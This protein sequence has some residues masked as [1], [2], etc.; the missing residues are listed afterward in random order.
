MTSVLFALVLGSALGWFVARRSSSPRGLG[1]AAGAHLLPDPA[2]QWL[3]R[4][5]RGLGV[6]VAEYD[7]EEQAPTLERVLDAD[8][9]PPAQVAA[10]DRR[11]ERAREQE[12]GGAERLDAGLFVMRASGGCAV[13]LL[14]A[15]AEAL[16]EVEADLD[17]LLA[18]VR[19][20]PIVSMAQARPDALAIESVGSVSLRLAYQLERITNAAVVVASKDIDGVRVTGTSGHADRRLLD[21]LLPSGSG[22]ARAAGGTLAEDGVQAD[23][24]G[25]TGDRRQGGGPAFVVRIRSGS[26]VVGAVAVWVPGGGEP[27]G[28]ALG[29]ILECVREAGPR[30]DNAQQH[31]NKAKEAATDRLTG[32]ANRRALEAA[33]SRQGLVRGVLVVLDIDHFKRLNDAL[34][35]PAGDAALLHVGQLIREQ[36]RTSDTA[37]RIGGEEFALWLPGADLEIGRRTADRIRTKLGTT[38][39]EWQGRPWPLSASFGVAAFPESS[40]SIQNLLTHADRA[41]YVAKES[42]RNRVEVAG[43]GAG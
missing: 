33:M 27:R 29:E 26:Q 20:R 23:P 38:A 4:A 5:H 24:T 10:I 14:L 16:T 13:G 17:R 32:L 8:G 40:P 34:G 12:Q 41:L 18:G 22:L 39:W 1:T 9:L 25:D 7:A 15:D 2:L 21:R 37:A 6:W 35:H 31:A 43:G 42:G 19:R 36:V 28:P 30:L 11:L 3:L